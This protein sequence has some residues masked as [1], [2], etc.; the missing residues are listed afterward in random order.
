MQGRHL[1][2]VNADVPERWKDLQGIRPPLPSLRLPT[3]IPACSLDL[4]KRRK[5]NE[6]KSCLRVILFSAGVPSLSQLKRRGLMQ[7]CLRN[8]R[9]M[10]TLIAISP[11]LQGESERERLRPTRLPPVAVSFFYFPGR[12]GEGRDG[13]D[14]SNRLFI[15][16]WV[17]FL[18]VSGKQPAFLSARRAHGKVPNECS[19]FYEYF[20]N[21]SGSG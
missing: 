4:S 10:S 19:Q 12:K 15:A 3:S 14:G 7:L 6:K 11:F 9:S 8:L 21:D 2:T 18:S 13:K 20:N 16:S 5:Q 17:F 1:K